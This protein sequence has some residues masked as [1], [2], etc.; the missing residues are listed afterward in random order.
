MLSSMTIRVGSSGQS[1]EQCCRRAAATG[2]AVQ[3]LVNRFHL[4]F[5]LHQELSGVL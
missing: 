4:V 1:I 2:K 5:D 3:T